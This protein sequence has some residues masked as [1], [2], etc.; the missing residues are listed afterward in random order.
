VE[1]SKHIRSS[2]RLGGRCYS[3]QLLVQQL[4]ASGVAWAGWPC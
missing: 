4:L 2:C 1:I 3:T